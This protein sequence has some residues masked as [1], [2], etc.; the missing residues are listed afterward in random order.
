MNQ[1][2][3][4][5]R[6]GRVWY[7]GRSGWCLGE[8]DSPIFTNRLNAERTRSRELKITKELSETRPD[9]PWEVR[10]HALWC[11]AEIVEYEM[12]PVP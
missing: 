8:H 5:I 6:S 10:N 11:A 3:Y 7:K 4:K 12:V 2:L 9:L 1:R